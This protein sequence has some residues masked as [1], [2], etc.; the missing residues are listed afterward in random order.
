MSG[1]KDEEFVMPGSASDIQGSNVDEQEVTPHPANEENKKT[2]EVEWI[3]Y[4]V[5]VVILLG[6][7]YGLYRVVSGFFEGD[8][9]EKIALSQTKQVEEPVKMADPAKDSTA[10]DQAKL[11]LLEKQSEKN[12]N[13]STLEQF[14]QM[15]LDTKTNQEALRA[16][17]EQQKE[18]L[19]DLH[20]SLAETTKNLSQLSGTESSNDQANIDFASTLRKIIEKQEE[21]EVAIK[22][23]IARLNKPAEAKEPNH[24]TLIAAIEGRAWIQN[25]D[26]R[27]TTV[28][29]GDAVKDYGKVTMI[30]PRNGMVETSSGQ[31]IQFN[32]P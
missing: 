9:P 10:V 12:T 20:K 4:V 1:P 2:E 22:L 7:G 24:Y 28:A 30:D 16:M 32:H 3:Y 19:A 27:E 26:G 5:L 17:V 13:N 21:Q 6:I 29:V 11:E 14:N 31:T 23:L 25:Q 15:L 8:T 18:A